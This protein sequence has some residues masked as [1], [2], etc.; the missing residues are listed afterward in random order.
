MK[1][2]IASLGSAA[3]V[4]LALCSRLS[5]AGAFTIDQALSAPFP[6]DLTAA[7]NKIA[8]VF[9]SRGVRNVWVAEGPDF[10]A[11]QLTS[12]NTDDG[13]EIGEIAWSGDGSSLVYT[14]GGP[15]NA[16]G[17]YPNPTSNP[18]GVTQSVFAIAFSGGEPRL[19]GNG[20]SPS[21]SPDSKTVIFISHGQIWSAPADGS[22]PAHQLIH[23]RGTSEELRWSPDGSMLAFTSLRGD[24]SFI[25]VYTFAT[26]Q[27]HFLDPSVDRDGCAGWSPDGARIVFRRVPAA[28][29]FYDHPARPSSANPWSI[30][31]AD[32]KTGAG[33]EV[34]KADPGVGS[35]VREM[36]AANQLFWGE[37]DRI[38]FPWERDGWLHLYSVDAGGGAAVLLTPGEFEIENA[39]LSPDRGSVVYSSNQEDIDRRHLWRVPVSEARPVALTHGE[40]IEYAAAVLA[41]TRQLR[42]CTPMRGFPRVPQCSPAVSLAISPPRRCH[43]IFLP[44]PWQRRNR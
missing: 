29:T 9:D 3:A 26:K 35:A 10:K 23:A 27:L 2:S 7:G 22:K 20:D 16:K 8:W 24:H 4:T 40:G 38:V 25:G 43:P 1:I 12:Y 17:E 14:R 28:R 41:I 33:R 42:C 39:A 21:I 18:A 5:G 32:A 30:R 15:A 11:R 6:S 31:V 44:L 13:Q 19:V 37:G 36:V 34:W